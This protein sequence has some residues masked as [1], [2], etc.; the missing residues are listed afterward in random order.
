MQYRIIPSAVSVTQQTT[1]SGICH[2]PCISTIP[3]LAGIFFKIQSC[4]GFL[5]GAEVKNLSTKVWD[6]GDISLTSGLGRYPG[7]GN[8]N[9]LQDSCLEDSMD[10]GAWKATVHR[11]QK[12]QTWMSTHSPKFQKSIK[13]L[14]T[15][16]KLVQRLHIILSSQDSSLNRGSGILGVWIL[17]Q[18]WQFYISMSEFHFLPQDQSIHDGN[19]CGQG[20]KPGDEHVP[21]AH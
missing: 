5:G 2:H 16:K 3:S 20:W 1:Q 19:G 15:F 11:L 13:T 12:S 18:F 21:C 17:K 9:P 14:S 10:R 6:A 4:K 7:G 8:G